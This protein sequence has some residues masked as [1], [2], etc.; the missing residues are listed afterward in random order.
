[1]IEEHARAALTR[2]L[3]D[4]GLQAGDVGTVVAVHNLGEGYTVEFNNVDGTL[5]ALPPLSADCVRPASDGDWARYRR[6][7][8]QLERFPRDS[9]RTRT[10]NTLRS[11]PSPVAPRAHP[12]DAGEDDRA[13]GSD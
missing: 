10:R 1:M 12:H 7:R 4:H 8:T 13:C 3:L 2:D 5:L 6:T 9:D 11:P